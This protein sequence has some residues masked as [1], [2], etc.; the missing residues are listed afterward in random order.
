[1]IEETS[2]NERMSRLTWVAQRD[3]DRALAL[4][5]APSAVRESLTLLFVIDL[6]LAAV[7]D[8][9]GEPGAALLRLAW[10]RDAL[11]AL[12]QG[13]PPPEPM[14]QAVSRILVSRGIS[15]ASLARIA[16]GWLALAEDEA[17]SQAAIDEHAAERGGT[18]FAIAGQLCGA[19][20]DRLAQAGAGW[21]LAERAG[22]VD[23]PARAARLA[24]AA[25]ARFAQLSGSPW[26]RRL[27]ALG[28]LVVLGRHDLARNA[29]RARPARLLR[30][31]RLRLTGR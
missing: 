23:D 13:A 1:V 6:R 11:T 9:G 4:L 7:A 17:G 5:A 18:L 25:R 19:E 16:E 20:D 2:E 21:A 12:D 27:R 29:P 14:L 22:H 28:T 26:P 3:P 15:G 30:A 24:A 31:L 10:W 8:R